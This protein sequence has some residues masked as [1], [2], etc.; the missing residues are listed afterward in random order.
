MS[1]HIAWKFPQ[2]FWVANIVELFERASFYGVFIALSLY[3]SD[4]VGFDDIEAGWIGAFY[5]G[6]LYFL[7]PF[8]GA[9]ADKMG[10][11]NAMLLAFGLLAVGFFTL[12]AL[13]YK[14]TV[15]P[16][17][18]LLIIGG[19]FIKGLITGTVAKTSTTEQ[20][21]RAFSIFYGMVNV[22][23]F[24]G[25]TI[26]Y[27]LRLNLGLESINYFSALLCA[28][29]VI[30]VF[31]FYRN[32]SAVGEG[33]SVREIWR[34]FM[35]VVLNVRLVTLI[36]IVAGFWIIQGQ[37]YATMPKYV[38]RL[39]GKNASPEWIANVNPAVV[40]VCVVLVTHLMR[41]AQAITS[42]NIGMLIMPLSA[43]C[44]SASPTLEAWVGP[45]VSLPFGISAHPITVTLIAGIVLQGLAECFISPRYLE[46][47]SKQ[48]P[49]GEEGLYLGFSHLHSFV[50]YVLGFSLS[51]YLLAK[52]CPDPKTVAPEQMATAYADA[53]FIWYYFA[54]I[55]LLS[56][57]ALFIYAMVT[58]RIDRGKRQEFANHPTS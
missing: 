3:L 20:R 28:A 42:M 53:N 50:A 41:R 24:T 31:F 13:P 12:G 52:Y 11:R 7:P 6:G 56:A 9:T 58:D 27:P 14:P 51:G 21:A 46:F 35:R 32:V 36:L 38:I 39:V 23:S 43:L 19:S 1:S 37:M 55:G 48:A 8:T 45:S 18:V 4:V 2:A 22:G 33:K 17:I 40:V 47:F 44:M 54:A 15:I 30:V 5:A 57:I 29:A 26:A 25:K 16:A 10:F 49:K 34:G